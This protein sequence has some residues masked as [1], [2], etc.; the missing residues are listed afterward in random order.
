MG[1][2]DERQQVM[3]AHRPDR[4]VAGDDEFVVPLVVVEAGE[5]EPAR[6]QQLGVGARHP[7][8]RLGKPAG[9]QVDGG[10]FC[11]DQVPVRSP[12]IDAQGGS[13]HG[14]PFA[15]R[16]AQTRLF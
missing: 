16:R 7:G 10:E 2:T 8:G 1:D 3:F 14:A 5:G 12:L 9:A 6:G 15:R 11:G 4:D 13:G